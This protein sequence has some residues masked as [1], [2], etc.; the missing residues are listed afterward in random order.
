MD[1]K[2]KD[3]ANACYHY[4]CDTAKLNESLAQIVELRK[5]SWLSDEN[6]HSVT[7]L[8]FRIKLKIQTLKFLTGG[9]L[10]NAYVDTINFAKAVKTESEK[11]GYA[12]TAD[13]ASAVIE[14]LEKVNAITFDAE[15]EAYRVRDDEW[16]S[17]ITS[18]E[19]GQA[20]KAVFDAKIAQASLLKLGVDLFGEKVRFIPVRD[21]L[22]A[23]LKQISDFAGEQ[24]A[25]MAKE[26]ESALIKKSAVE[27]ENRYA[28]YRYYP[29]ISD[30][31]RANSIV[32]CSPIK[33]EFLLYCQFSTKDNPAGVTVI[34]LATVTSDTALSAILGA[35]K[36]KSSHLAVVN[37]NEYRGD[38]EFLYKSLI[39]FGKS[40][41][42]AIIHDRSGD[43]KLYSQMLSYAQKSEEFTALDISF[44]YLSMPSY[45][46]MVELFN[47][48]NMLKDGYEEKIKNNLAFMGFVGINECVKISAIG[49]D[50]LT[51][52]KQI[53]LENERA[54]KEYL[55]QT[56]SQMQLLDSGWGDYTADRE[57]SLAHYEFS[58]DGV[59]PFSVKNVKK[60]MEHDCSLFAKCGLLVRYA[61]LHGE[62]K[63]VWKDL[64]SEEKADRM[65][66]ATKLV[67]KALCI[68]IDPIVE[69][70][71]TLDVAWAGGLCIDGGKKVQYQ[72]KSSEGIDWLM[73]C[74]CHESYHAFQHHAEVGEYKQWYWNLLGVT[75]GGLEQVKLNFEVRRR[76]DVDSISDDIYKIQLTE[77]EARA[78]AK[79]CLTQADNEI[80][81]ID[82][83]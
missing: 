45:R 1:I 67:F 83:E 70:K 18:I 42:K 12:K 35:V 69:V 74:V 49:R 38:T 61:L 79:N 60:I 9:Y 77:S 68:P 80:N 44:A 31:V 6:K 21:N 76:V 19:Q 30:G 15:A 24:I 75:S 3:T 73:D 71:K 81:A 53:S 40:G 37:A 66:E 8:G 54:C 82:W 39:L 65:T 16:N 25:R 63:S 43:R 78:F 26:K 7:A 22:V 29:V 13:L 46:E 5:Q 41:K 17:V 48:L 4:S 52:G 72:E 33:D 64:P 34:D 10:Q 59:R 20:V 51:A 50:W 14:Y 47:S 58:Y 2:V 36:E 23:D 56:P 55:A 28:N 11:S 32:I 57:V 62:D 27:V